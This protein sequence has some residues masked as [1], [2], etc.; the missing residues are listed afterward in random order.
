VSCEIQIFG[1]PAQNS[2]F[3]GD[4]VEVHEDRTIEIG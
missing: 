2:R 4:S 1:I 3:G